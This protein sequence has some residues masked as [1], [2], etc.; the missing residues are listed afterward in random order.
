MCPECRRWWFR[1]TKTRLAAG[2]RPNPLCELTALPQTPQ[3]DSEGKGGIGRR[4]SEGGEKRDGERRGG[5]VKGGI[6]LPT[7][8]LLPPPMYVTFSLQIPMSQHCK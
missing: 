6:G 7:F 3:L 1:F 2:L 4:G 8:W 5:M